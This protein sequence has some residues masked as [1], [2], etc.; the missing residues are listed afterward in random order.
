MVGTSW[1]A[2]LPFTTETQS[3]QRVAVRTQ[4]SVLCGCF[5]VPSVPLWWLF[6]LASGIS[7]AGA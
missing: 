5:S 7:N 4:K 3:A 2:A 6:N 1:I